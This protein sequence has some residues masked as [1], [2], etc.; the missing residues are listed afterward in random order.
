M[1]YRSDYIGRGN[2][3]QVWAP[4]AGLGDST[5]GSIWSALTG[6]LAAGRAVGQLAAQVAPQPATAPANAFHFAT[7]TEVAQMAF[8]GKPVPLAQIS[9]NAQVRAYAAGGYKVAY[10]RYGNTKMLAWG[11]AAIAYLNV[12]RAAQA[13]QNQLASAS[14]LV[15]QLQFADRLAD[16]ARKT[17]AMA[18][19]EAPPQ[20]DLSPNA[21]PVPAQIGQPLLGG[22]G[23]FGGGMGTVLL[24][25][26]GFLAAGKFF[27][28]KGRKGR[29][30]GRKGRKGR[31]RKRS[32]RRRG[33]RRRR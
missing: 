10:A 18:K 33:R 9:T 15:A 2:L 13:G 8:A 6:G 7:M 31:G 23:G 22:F 4:V 17:E 1:S 11:Q 21:P 32:G 5:W 24:V 20:L 29:G 28:K 16:N 25:F 26:G 3:D 12:W 19:N 27:G 30:K 14:S